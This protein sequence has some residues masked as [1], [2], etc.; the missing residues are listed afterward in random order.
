[1]ALTKIASA[2]YL[3]TSFFNDQEPL[4]WRL[5]VLSNDLISLSVKDKKST[6]EEIVSLFNLAKNANLVSELNHEILTKE[7]KSFI[8]ESKNPLESILIPEAKQ[9]REPVASPDL[10]KF[11]KDNIPKLREFGV[12]TVKKNSRQS[13]IFSLLKRKKEIMIKD[14]SP[15]IGGCSE[16]TI[17]IELAD[18]VS[19]GILRRIGEKRWSRYTLAENAK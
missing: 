13:V 7:L 19:K 15:L 16:K 5:R 3:V 2:I 10:P 17:Q 8:E 12:V 4:K 11:I 18:M 14:V 1:M 9:I 6:A